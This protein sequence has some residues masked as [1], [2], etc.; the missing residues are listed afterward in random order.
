[1]CGIDCGIG[2]QLG[3]EHMFELT[4]NSFD[5][6]VFGCGGN[7]LA[8]ANE[9]AH[10]NR[11]YSQVHRAYHTKQHLA[12]CLAH[13]RVADAEMPESAGSAQQIAE[14]AL[15]LWYHDAVY[16]PQ[17]DDNETRS[18]RWFRFRAQQF[19]IASSCI[20]RLSAMILA[21]RHGIAVAPEG[22]QT[23]LLLDIDLAILAATP[24]RFREYC[25]QIRVEYAFVPD[26]IFAQKRAQV[27]RE[28]LTPKKIYNSNVG[29]RF[30][31]A[32]RLN[33]TNEIVRLVS[34]RQ[35]AKHTKLKSS[36]F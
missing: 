24:A 5:A 9:Y 6:A 17:R 2:A 13:L 21:T 19:G 26:A 33:L 25:E 28:F 11:A 27:L 3:R 1:M 12:E 8:Q 22:A 31:V 4:K 16:R 20:Q 32:A 14:I 7:P 30:E 15:A 18:A 10:L 34:L 29:A 23:Q 35:K 36:L